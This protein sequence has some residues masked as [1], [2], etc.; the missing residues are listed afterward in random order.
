MLGQLLG[1]FATRQALEDSP[2]QLLEGVEAHRALDRFTDDHRAFKAGCRVLEPQCR[3]Y[4]PV[5]MDVVLDFFLV[6]NWS[7]FSTDLSF[8]QYLTRLY[9]ALSTQ[10]ESLPER[11]K[12]PATRMYEMDWFSGFADLKGLETVFYYM[13]K[14]V[15]R[16]EWIRQ[17]ASCVQA[18]TAVLEPLCLELLRDEAL[19]NFASPRF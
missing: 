5:V 7:D 18:N 6:K 2:P 12:I 15:R 16:A 11:M 3:R 17:A 19:I 14:R 13:A 8:E 4:S 9:G 1:D 10:S